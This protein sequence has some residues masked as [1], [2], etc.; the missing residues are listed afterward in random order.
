M[1]KKIIVKLLQMIATDYSLMLEEKSNSK[2]KM[3]RVTNQNSVNF[4][5]VHYNQ[6]VLPKQGSII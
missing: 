1:L 3:L 5:N 6:V 2:I 4:E